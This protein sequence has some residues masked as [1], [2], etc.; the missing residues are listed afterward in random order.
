MGAA[1]AEPHA[2]FC[3]A[4]LFFPGLLPLR[5]KLALLCLDKVVLP[6]HAVGDARDEL[7]DGQRFLA[8][9]FALAQLAHQVFQ[10]APR[11]PQ[12][13]AAFG[14]LLLP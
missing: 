1:S 12:E 2:V 3:D 8:R 5:L 13:F 6:R 4:L 9:D 11:F 10:L 14:M 7:P